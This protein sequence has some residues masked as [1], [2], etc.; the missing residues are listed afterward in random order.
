[1]GIIKSLSKKNA[2][3][4]IFSPRDEKTEINTF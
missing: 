1:M 3:N 2:E 4:L